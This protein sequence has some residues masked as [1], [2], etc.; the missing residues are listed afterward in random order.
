MREARG[1]RRRIRRVG[2]QTQTPRQPGVTLGNARH[3]KRFPA[4]NGAARQ[5]K[6]LNRQFFCVDC[7][8]S[9]RR[10]AAMLYGMANRETGRLGIEAEET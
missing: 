1:M 3:C 6:L 2:K 5:H 7:R 9:Y 10:R 8:V 4:G